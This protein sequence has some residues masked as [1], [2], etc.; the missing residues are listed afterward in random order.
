M[1][2]EK[3]FYGILSIALFVI[4]AFTFWEFIFE[5]CHMAGCIVSGTPSEAIRELWR[6]FPL[7]LTA[8]V[9][10]YLASYVFK[11]YC[12]EKAD[13]RARVWVRNGYIAS[14][15]GLIVVVYTLVG[16]LTGRYERIVEGFPSPLFPLDMIIGGLL[17]AAFGVFSVV[18]GRRIERK[19]RVLA[20]SRIKGFF[21]LFHVISYMMALCGF[22]AFA[23]G[24]FDVDF[25]HGNI[26]F[27]IMLLLN[28]LTAAVMALVYRFV[29][30][31]S[32]RLVRTSRRLSLSFLIVNILLF[33]LYL[34]SVQLE[35]EAPNLNAFA[36]LPIEFT[37]SF[38]AFMIA[39]GLNNIVVPLGAFVRGL[40]K[41]DK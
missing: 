20:F 2:K 29:Y 39:Y 30:A 6:M 27:N 5:L 21:R 34:L 24:L 40:L 11:A 3:R 33:G 9:E 35:N 31:E 26:F 16:M 37:A 22:A 17:I 25:S 4:N 18:Y 13:R 28:Y 14:A 36:I 19:G 15:L 7:I 8:F 38:N 32:D 10:I 1:S 12:T 23:Y 41:K